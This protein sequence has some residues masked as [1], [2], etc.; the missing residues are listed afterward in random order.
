[1]SAEFA[2]DLVCLFFISLDDLITCA[3]IPYTV[4]IRTFY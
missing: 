3:N 2:G 1:M 4:Q